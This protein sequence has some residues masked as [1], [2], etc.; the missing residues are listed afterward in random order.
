MATGRGDRGV[1]SRWRQ[2]VCRRYARVDPFDGIFGYRVA[3]LVD[4]ILARP[5]VQETSLS[6]DALFALVAEKVRP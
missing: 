4:A 2:V 3:R 6:E 5:S 1:D